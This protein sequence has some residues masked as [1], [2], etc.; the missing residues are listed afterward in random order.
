MT[1]RNRVSAAVA[2]LAIGAAGIAFA[3][4]EE[5]F[6]RTYPLAPDGRISLDNINGDVTVEVW[7][8]AEVRVWAVKRASDADR[9]R[10]LRIEVD[11]SDR[12]LRIRT[13]YPSSRGFG[14]GDRG[15]SEVEYSLTVPRGA[16]IDG[17]DLINGNLRIVGVEGGVEV[18]SVN[19]D[20]E[21]EGVWAPI[22]LES[23]N[24]TIDVRLDALAPG[25]EVK[26]DSV[27]GRI[28]V[29]LAP[30]VGA[31][32]DV[33]TVNGSIRNDFG[34]PVHKGKY[35][36]RDL[37]GAIGG[38]GAELSIETVNGAIRINEG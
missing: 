1:L 15:H 14:S 33:E 28:E 9:L 21:L 10:D 5:T 26:L 17:F 2:V 23:V 35:V 19:G 7:D 37:R 8:N 32:L 30:G 38:G 20:I 4:V 11:A 18:D 25:D 12:D 3:Q 22:E 27:N 6:D 31:D 13:E 16:E 36:G 29:F 34:L 24:G